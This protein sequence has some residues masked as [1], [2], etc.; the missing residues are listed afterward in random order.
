M[1]SNDI[2]QQ[3]SADYGISF[4]RARKL[5]AV[6]RSEQQEEILAMIEGLLIS[7]RRDGEIKRVIAATY[8]YEPRSVS[9]KIAVARERLRESEGKSIEDLRAES[10]G[11]YRQFARDGKLPANI[12][13]K[14]REAMDRIR[15]LNKSARE[16]GM[17]VNLTPEDVAK[18]SLEE[19]DALHEKLFG[20]PP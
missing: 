13:L 7:D 2:A 5:V 3:I 9:D 6:A 1:L 20:S 4:K 14:A 19:I 8:G 12:R 17:N 18:M 11:F 10:L 15:G 16:V